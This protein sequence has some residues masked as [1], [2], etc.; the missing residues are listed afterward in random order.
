MKDLG[1]LFPRLFEA[2]LVIIDAEVTFL[3]DKVYDVLSL[4]NEHLVSAT[5]PGYMKGPVD[6]AYKL[7]NALLQATQLLEEICLTGSIL[8]HDATSEKGHP[9]RLPKWLS[10][11]SLKDSRM[12][13]YLAMLWWTDLDLP[14]DHLKTAPSFVHTKTSQAL[15][16]VPSSWKCLARCGNGW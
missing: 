11:S 5:V 4:I 3:P 14:T 8:S 7:T 2:L 13:H 9:T 1:C 12:W 10:L 16:K 15:R 6:M